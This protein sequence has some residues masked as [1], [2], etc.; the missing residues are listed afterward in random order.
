MKIRGHVYWKDTPEQDPRW[1]QGVLNVADGKVHL[2]QDRGQEA[3]LEGWVVPG[4]VDLHAHLTLG[5]DG[6]VDAQEIEQNAWAE[7]EAGVLAVREPGSPVPIPPAA[8]PYGRP[9]VVTSG[10]HIALERRYIRGLAEEVANDTPEQVKR[11]LVALVKQEAKNGDGWVK[12]VGDW[13]DRSLGEDSDLLPLW[14]KEQLQA[15]VDTAHE[16]G[17]QVCVHTFSADAIP[18]LLAAGVDSIE[19]GSGMSLEEMRTAADLGIPVVP[20]TAQVLKFP[21]FAQAATRYPKYA[22]TM[23]TL[24]ERRRQWFSDLLASG[25]ELL[26]GSDAGGYQQ[27]GSVI[28]ELQR[29]VEWGMEPAAVL[30]AATWKARDFLGLPGLQP[31]APA[32]LVVFADDPS[33]NSDLWDQPAAVVAAGHLLA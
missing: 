13:I 29:W 12:L 20:T 2:E 1:E 23:Q 21:E 3:D 27:H 11:D 8:L 17:A 15:A 25:V 28:S 18:D 33:Q 16:E 7:L 22:H 32:D 24:Y 30:E 26:P 4:F 19:H 9:V 6:V 31:D 10:K 14:T 5:E